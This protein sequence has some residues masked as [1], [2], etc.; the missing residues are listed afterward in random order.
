MDTMGKGAIQGFISALICIPLMLLMFL[1][2]SYIGFD[3]IIA[4]SID[5]GMFF[6]VVLICS[7]IACIEWKV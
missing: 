1:L 2:I 3:T 6:I 4:R 7:A 5:V